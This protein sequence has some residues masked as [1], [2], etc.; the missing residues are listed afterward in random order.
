[1]MNI[2]LKIC[3]C[4]GGEV[5]GGRVI[6][7]HLKICDEH[8]FKIWFLCWERVMNIDLKI[9]FCEFKR[10]KSKSS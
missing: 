8:T 2:L 1:M 6:N 7:I 9:C 5:G 10:K 4:P 3:L